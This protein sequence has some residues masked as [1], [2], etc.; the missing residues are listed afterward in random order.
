MWKM[1]GLKREKDGPGM[2]SLSH[3]SADRTVLVPAAVCLAS[4]VSRKQSSDKVFVKCH[5]G[6]S[7]SWKRHSFRETL[8]SR[9]TLL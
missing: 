9:Q 1:M 7:A 3:G 6:L 2:P 4:P 5:L 8:A